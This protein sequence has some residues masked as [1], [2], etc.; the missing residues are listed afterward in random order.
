[1][2]EASKKASEAS[3]TRTP[4]GFRTENTMTTPVLVKKDYRPVMT[5]DTAHQQ[6]RRMHGSIREW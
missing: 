2:I 4:F 5:R 3:I 6:G 1:V